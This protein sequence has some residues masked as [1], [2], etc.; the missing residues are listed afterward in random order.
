[1]VL[2]ID[3]HSK[4]NLS[5]TTIIWAKAKL[6]CTGGAPYNVPQPTLHICKVPTA[7][8]GRQAAHTPRTNA[9]STTHQCTELPR[10]M[11]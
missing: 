6:V 8:V 3:P 7:L 10:V 2:T 11:P 9:Q 4:Q 1:M 5:E